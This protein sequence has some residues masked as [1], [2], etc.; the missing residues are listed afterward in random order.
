MILSARS[1]SDALQPGDPGDV[2]EAVHA[3]VFARPQVDERLRG[4][5]AHSPQPVRPGAR[6]ARAARAP[7]QRAAHVRQGRAR[8]CDRALH[9][10]TRR[11]GLR[12]LLPYITITSDYIS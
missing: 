12:V 8:H 2:E 1:C 9:E 11:C 6:A 5:G 7:G 10:D 3:R 4:A